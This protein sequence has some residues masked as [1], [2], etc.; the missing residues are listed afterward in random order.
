METSFAGADCYWNYLKSIGLSLNSDMSARIAMS[1]EGT[2]WDNPTSALE[3]NNCAV[4]ALIE[5]EQC[6][7]SSV[8]GLYLE[9]AL[10]ALNSGVELSDYPLCAAHLALVFAMTG[11]MEQAIHTAFPLFVNSLQ[12]AYVND[13]PV[14]SG[15]VYLPSS[16][17]TGSSCELLAQILQTKDGYTQSLLLLSKVLCQSQ[18]VFYNS[19]GLRFLHLAAQLF[20]NSASIN[21]KLGLASLINNQQEGF[22][23]LQRARTLAP[24]SAIIV[25]TLYLAYRDLGQMEVANFWLGIG[26]DMTQKSQHSLDSQWTNIEAD[27]PITY[28][29]F[30]EQLQLA[31]EPSLGSLVTSVLLAEGDWF[32]KEMEFWRSWLKPGMTV[33]DVGANVGVYTFSAALQVGAE[34][35]VL[36]VEPFSGCVRC[37]QE[38]C[39]INQLSWVKVCAGAASDRN[40]KVKL[41]LHTASELNEVVSDDTEETM[42]PGTFEEVACFTLDSL[43][44][45]ES[46]NQVN[47]LKID[48]E[49]HEIKVLE[50]CDRILKEFSPTILYENIA[51]RKGSNLAVADFLKS[52]GYQLFRYQPYLQQLI[53]I[54]STNDLQGRL[55]IIA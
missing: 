14:P 6:Q 20:P 4:V 24:A 5:A 12:S 17:D 37:L 30:E 29:R 34:G 23:Y 42:K 46:V 53:P 43:I 3:L 8:R 48:A 33:I 51:G 16:R 11:D 49:G 50:G 54:N 10:D 18:L 47:F 55:N 2:A 41:A 44:E 9:M 36:A 31:V 1:L 35:C 15:I 25:Q 19:L 45:Q 28:I 22:L 27:S 13:K 26:R 7:D 40:G 32:E 21:L 52:R 39:R 38:T